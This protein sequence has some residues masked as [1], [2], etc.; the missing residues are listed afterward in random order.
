MTKEIYQLLE[1][2]M[3]SCMDVAG[4]DPEH[5]YRVLYN[6][7]QIEKNTAGVDT[8]ILIAAC[9][10]HDIGRKEQSE[11]PALCHA[12]VGGEKA[13]IFLLENGFGETFAQRVKDCIQT[14]RFRKN[15]QPESI[16]AKI[17][18]DADK[19]DVTGAIGIART[20]AYE[21]EVGE[22]LYVKR[23]D[24][25]ICDGVGT[26]IPSFFHEYKFKLEKL[27]ER[28]YTEAG[29]NMAQ[30]RKQIAVDFYH[31]LYREVGES[32]AEG[33]KLLERNLYEF[34]A[35]KT[36]SGRSGKGL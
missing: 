17:L 35:G 5:V 11:N 30:S 32:Y 20:L 14:H 26:D 24:G 18:F 21:A 9:L 22:P 6:A 36:N 27:Y 29:R 31:A 4:H 15:R 12:L 28:F 34:K 10:L 16:E 1:N 8:D 23:A 3:L 2:Y 25:S 7:L 13:Y 19:L 33:Q